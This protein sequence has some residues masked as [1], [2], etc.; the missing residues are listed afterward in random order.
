MR[1]NRCTSLASWG[2]LSTVLHG[3]YIVL[4]LSLG[5]S[6]SCFVIKSRKLPEQVCSL[7]LMDGGRNFYGLFFEIFKLLVVGFDMEN[8]FVVRIPY[9]FGDCCTESTCLGVIKIRKLQN[10]KT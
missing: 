7:I 3:I 4:N 5:L 8:Q 2:T 1:M 9:A 10:K 6:L